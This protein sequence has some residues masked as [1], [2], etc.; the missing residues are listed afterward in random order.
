MVYVAIVRDMNNLIFNLL[1]HFQMW[2][3]V[4]MER[5]DLLMVL[6]YRKVELKFVLMEYGVVSVNMASIQLMLMSSVLS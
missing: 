4:M 3:S 2:D 5:Y 1:Q 6:L